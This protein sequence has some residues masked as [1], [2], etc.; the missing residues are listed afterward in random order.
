M[1]TTVD[2]YQN[3]SAIN[4]DALSEITDFASAIQMLNDTG[5]VAESI[6]D[7]GTGFTVVDKNRLVDVPFIIVEWRFNEGDYKDENGEN[8]H[9]A[10]AAVVTKNGD[11]WIIN[12]GGTGVCEQLRS[13]T[14]KRVEK[15]HPTPQN[16][17]MVPAGLVRSDYE[18]ADAKGVMQ[19]GTTFY[20]S[21]SPTP[22]L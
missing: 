8:M 4:K 3:G 6:S 13:V 21:E 7:Y 11:K 5:V 16:G 22:T 12:D 19:P 14:R 2:I 15:K 17:L 20:L 9:F 18:F 1:T 10:S